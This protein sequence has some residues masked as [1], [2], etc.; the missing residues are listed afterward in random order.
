MSRASGMTKWNTLADEIGQN[1]TIPIHPFGELCF[2]AWRLRPAPTRQAIPQLRRLA[3]NETPDT[4][5]SSL[6]LVR[7]PAD[8]HYQLRV[9]YQSQNATKPLDIV[10][11]HLHELPKLVRSPEHSHGPGCAR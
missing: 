7:N 11:E 8:K 2:G 6:L 4:D 3:G 10:R 1:P 5:A 9:I